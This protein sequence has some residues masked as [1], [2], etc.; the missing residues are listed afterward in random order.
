M[1]S[2]FKSA[3]DTVLGM[4]MLLRFSALLY[5]PLQR[6]SLRVFSLALHSTALWGRASREVVLCLRLLHI[7]F[8]R[9]GLH[10][11]IS[12]VNL[13]ALVHLTFVLRKL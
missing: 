2:T 8:E 5:V 4:Q 1:H 13:R 11:A 3:T 10:A 6:V 12:H 9:Q 7:A